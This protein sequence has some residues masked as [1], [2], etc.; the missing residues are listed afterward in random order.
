VK[1]N[2]QYRA[3]RIGYFR[4]LRPHT[5]AALNVWQNIQSIA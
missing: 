2:Q 4:S 3:N 1:W 5:T